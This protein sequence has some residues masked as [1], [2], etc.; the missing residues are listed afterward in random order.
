LLKRTAF[1]IHIW[2][3]PKVRNATYLSQSLQN[4]IIEVIGYH[5]IHAYIAQEINQAP[6]YLI[7][8]DEVSAHNNEHLSLCL[9]YVDLHCEMTEIQEKFVAFVKLPRVRAADI[10]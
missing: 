10:M 5:Y 6:F 2:K 8:A 9:H 3:K 1:Y 7:I 4:N